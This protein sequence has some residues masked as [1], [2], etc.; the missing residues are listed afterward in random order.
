MP[1]IVNLTIENESM[2]PRIVGFYEYHNALKIFDQL[3]ALSTEEEMKVYDKALQDRPEFD[4]FVGHPGTAQ[5]GAERVVF[6]KA[7]KQ[8]GLSWVTALARVEL[9][10]MIASF[11]DRED[12]FKEVAPTKFDA[13]EFNQLLSEGWASHLISLQKLAQMN[14]AAKGKLAPGERGGAI[15]KIARRSKL[16]SDM[17]VVA[18]GTMNP[19][20]SEGKYEQL[21]KDYDQLQGYRDQLARELRRE[22]SRARNT[23]WNQSSWQTG[24]I[25]SCALGGVEMALNQGRFSVK[26]LSR[27]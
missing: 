27:Q 13:A 18:A 26:P 5:L 23:S 14:E 21:Q 25:P 4:I 17:V 10:S 12:P 3:A 19:A 16:A 1:N 11:S 24:H 6:R 15:V 2:L 22:V 7:F 20:T 8:S 9:G